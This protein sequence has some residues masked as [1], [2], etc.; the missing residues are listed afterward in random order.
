MYIDQ[1]EER[2]AQAN[3][4]TYESGYNQGFEAGRLAQK[5]PNYFPKFTYAWWGCKEGY[6]DGKESR[7][8]GYL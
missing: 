4:W 6:K 8:R 3:G 2:R 1:I 7:S 5:N